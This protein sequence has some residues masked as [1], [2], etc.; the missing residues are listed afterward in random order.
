MALSTTVRKINAHKARITVRDGRLTWHAVYNA[1]LNEAT[2]YLGRK[3]LGN[4]TAPRRMD[5]SGS[6]KAYYTFGDADVDLFY[7]DDAKYER[8][9]ASWDRV[10][11]AVA[12]AAVMFRTVAGRKPVA[13]KR[14]AR[15][16][17]KRSPR[18]TSGK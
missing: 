10:E 18:K 2:F 12:K 17:P 9:S 14:T 5:P 3:N 6:R 7:D 16:A 1:H 13:K 11:P 15:K 8:M 4:A